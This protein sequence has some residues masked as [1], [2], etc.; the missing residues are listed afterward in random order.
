L[1]ATRQAT[2]ALATVDPIVAGVDIIRLVK[3][4]GSGLTCAMPS[5]AEDRDALASIKTMAKISQAC[6][7]ARNECQSHQGSD[8][9]FA[10][11][12]AALLAQDGLMARRERLGLPAPSFYPIPVSLNATRIDGLPNESFDEHAKLFLKHLAKRFGPMSASKSIGSDWRADISLTHVQAC[13]LSALLVRMPKAIAPAASP[14][15]PPQITP[16][17]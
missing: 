3:K 9:F 17:T 12:E 8:A 16:S 5:C 10:R 15:T 14:Q 11:I 1:D 7:D 4:D 6:V 13:A 2:H